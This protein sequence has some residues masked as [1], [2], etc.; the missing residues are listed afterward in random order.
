M[1][2]LFTIVGFVAG[3]L[4]TLAFVPQVIYTYKVKSAGDFSWPMLLTFNCGLFLWFVY[5]IYLHSWPMILANAI[6]MFLQA[7]IIAMK[8]KYR[9]GNNEHAKASKIAR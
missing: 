9:N 8:L 5:G 1:S 6:T 2:S 3:T 7:F 4:T